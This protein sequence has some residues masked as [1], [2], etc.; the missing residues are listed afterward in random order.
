MC[1]GFSDR[2]LRCTI[3][4]FQWRQHRFD[5]D[6]QWRNGHPHPSRAKHE[7]LGNLAILRHPGCRTWQQLQGWR[8]EPR[9]RS[10]LL[11]RCRLGCFCFHREHAELK[12]RRNQNLQRQQC[13]RLRWKHPIP[14]L[15]DRRHAWKFQRSGF[16]LCR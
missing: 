12:W 15:F 4:R 13:Q 16:G 1:P 6:C 2:E 9:C 5:L 7:R 10:P 3:D 11:R 8:P 14:S